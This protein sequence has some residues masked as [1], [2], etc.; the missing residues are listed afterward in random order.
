MEQAIA[1][2]QPLAD[3][4]LVVPTD[5][6]LLARISIDLGNVLKALRRRPEAAEQFR[7]AIS[8]LES[9][10]RSSPGNPT[11]R[12]NLASALYNLANFQLEQPEGTNYW[13]NFERARDLCEGL[14][15]EFPSATSYSS[16]LASTHGNMGALHTFAGRL[17]DARA[18]FARTREI[19]ERLVRDNPTVLTYR[20]DL[21][22][23]YINLSDLESRAGRPGKAV[24]L[25]GP[26]CDSLRKVFRTREGDTQAREALSTAC[27]GLASS[28]DDLGRYPQALA[29]YRECADLELEL[30][31]KNDP[32]FRPGYT[33]LQTGLLGLARCYR[34]LGRI[35]EAVEAARQLCPPW[36]NRTPEPIAIARELTYCAVNVQDRAAAERYANRAIDFLRTAVATRHR[37]LESL[38]TDPA[39]DPLRSRPD[40]HD[41]LAD[42]AFPVN[43]FVK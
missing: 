6:D 29:A 42:A 9:L 18:S 1:V 43:P 36:P 20:I 16:L 26:A 4:S 32:H 30:L 22:K 5:P 17:E 11:Y 3:D 13:Q 19:C 35:S 37:G 23:T 25:L 40:F 24:E 10:V 38:R 31:R 33:R 14:V 7:A 12:C 34:Q 2:L 28:L 39:F 8:V 27:L 21:G 41:L 15:H